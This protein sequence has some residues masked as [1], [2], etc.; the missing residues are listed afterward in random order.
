MDRR[1]FLK[2]SAAGA[3]AA[4]AAGQT[5]K[6]RVGLVGCG[7]VSRP[8]LANM[9]QC[10]Y[11]ELVSVCDIVAE[12]AE[13]AGKKYNVK[14]YPHIDKQ[15]AGPEFELLVN[16]TG[17]PSHYPLN[18]QVLEAGRNVWSEKPM[19]TEVPKAEELLE[20]A[21][22]KGVKIWAAPT[23][24]TSPQF[25]FM[26]RQINSGGIGRAVAG[27][28][29]YGHDGQLWSAWFF[30]KQGGSLY[31]LGVYNVTSL[32][33]LLG[34]ARVVTGMNGIVVPERTLTDGTKVK[35]EAA[36]NEMLLMDHGNAAFSHVQSGF[37]YNDGH[38]HDGKGQRSTIDI[39][40]TK[41][42]MHLVG[43]DWAPHGVDLVTEE[44]P[45]PERH[46]VDPQGY[47]WQWGASY[48]AEHLA[49][50]KPSLITAEHALHVLEVM[51]ACKESQRTGRHIPIKSTF[52]WPV[53]A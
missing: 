38:A 48:I 14:W 7:S 10:P 23:V 12:R 11:I 40:G 26:A 15:L 28:A 32:T 9:A 22:K 21:H 4:G 44:K 16:T 31:D 43:Y 17:M 52:K 6:I 3:F 34:P 37:V 53:V 8:Y 42:H 45:A 1:A 27:H 41:G 24:V 20:L 51:N 13:N 2:T 50:G 25:A 5:K 49:T 39:I 30:Q 18:K 33:G 47:V 35:V 46:V 19:A 36:D 29:F